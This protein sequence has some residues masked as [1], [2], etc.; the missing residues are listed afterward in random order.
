M[1]SQFT[2]Y[3]AAKQWSRTTQVCPLS[4]AHAPSERNDL[5]GTLQGRGLRETID[6]LRQEDEFWNPCDGGSWY[7]WISTRA[8]TSVQVMS[9]IAKA[10]IAS[11]CLQK[12]HAFIH[13]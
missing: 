13:T 8:D 6:V 2:G 5:R 4:E 7:V 3:S 12:E 9:S 1:Q 10:R 11:R